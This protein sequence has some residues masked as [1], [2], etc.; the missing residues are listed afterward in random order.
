MKRLAVAYHCDCGQ[1]LILTNLDPAVLQRET[2]G[3]DVVI[4]KAFDQIS[5]P[6][7]G[8]PLA[9]VWQASQRTLAEDVLARLQS[10]GVDDLAH[11]LQTKLS[12]LQEARLRCN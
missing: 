3:I 7:C 12:A 10:L 9:P 8:A 1:R 4:L 6:D 5:C 11:A 2:Q